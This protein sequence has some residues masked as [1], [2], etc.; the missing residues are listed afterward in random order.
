VILK[1]GKAVDQMTTQI[2]KNVTLQIF[3]MYGMTDIRADASNKVAQVVRDN[4]CWILHLYFTDNVDLSG[5]HEVRTFDNKPLT[6][7][8]AKAWVIFGR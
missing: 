6:V 2:F 4:G 1:T 7:E 5:L 8:A 3:D